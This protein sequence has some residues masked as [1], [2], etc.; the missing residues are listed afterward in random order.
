MEHIGDGAAGR[1]LVMGILNVTPD[2][3]S[4][5]GLYVNADAAVERAYRMV[6]Q[7]AD[8]VD[9]G[10]ESTRPGATPLSARDEWDRIGSVVRTLANT[11]I[12]VSVDTYHAETARRAADA[13]AA[14]VNDVTGGHGDPSMLSA[15]A[16]TG[17]TYILQHN[18]GGGAS[19]DALASYGDVAA[20]VSG[21]LSASIDRAI[22]A[23]VD[24]SQI[25]VDPGFGFAKVGP[26]D[27]DLA[28]HMESVMS[29]GFPV[30]VGVSRK[31]FLAEI[32]SGGEGPERRDDATAAMTA[33]F[34]SLG[35]WA[36]RVHEGA[37]SRA[38]V[39]AVARLRRAGAYE[40]AA[41]AAP[42]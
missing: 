1:S 19:T 14:I 12:R 42:R 40:R 10:G 16:A 7:G 29:L 39:E 33:Y 8:I 36:V 15:V 24:A 28:A 34:A 2:S 17:C 30:L 41:Q 18:R 35:V 6:R 31:R 4:D 13:G 32:A 21:E 5:G 22:S 20:E 9:V 38:A 25:V 3:F 27:W 26:Q 23:G 11:P 37:A